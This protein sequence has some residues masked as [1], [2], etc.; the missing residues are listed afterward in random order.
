MKEESNLEEL[1]KNYSVIQQKHNLPSFEELN[2]D[3]Q[4]EKIAES[5]TDFLIREV[6]KFIAEKLSNYLRFV[7]MIL[8]PTNVPMSV[9]SIIKTLGTEDKDKL[10][11]IYKKLVKFEVDL[12]ETDVDFSEEK[13]AKFIRS[14]YIDWQE[15]KK[16][17]LG[18][19]EVIKNNLDNKFEKNGRRY[20]G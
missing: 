19:V 2:Q 10:T 3:F 18:V 13:E 8:Q 20:F 11:E 17:I 14:A 4:I 15:I 7:E 16:S 6:R 12:I 1:K 9:F 5:E